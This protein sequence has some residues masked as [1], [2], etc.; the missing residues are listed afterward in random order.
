MRADS[1]ALKL[2]FYVLVRT[3]G[4]LLFLLLLSACGSS[5]VQL[6]TSALPSTTTTNPVGLLEV[7][8]A[9][10]D[11]GA[12]ITIGNTNYE[13]SY[14]TALVADN[15]NIQV[16]SSCVYKQNDTIA[17]ASDMQVYLKRP[18]LPGTSS[19][20]I[21]S[22]VAIH[23]DE[24]NSWAEL[25]PDSPE[26]VLNTYGT[27]NA[28]DEAPDVQEM[29]DG[30]SPMTAI[31]IQSPDS[32][33]VAKLQVLNVSLDAKQKYAELIDINKKTM[34]HDPKSASLRA[35]DKEELAK[36]AAKKSLITRL[37][38]PTKIHAHSKDMIGD[39]GSVVLYHAHA[40][41]ILNN[42]GEAQWLRHHKE[43]QSQPLAPPALPMA[44]TEVSNNF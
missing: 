24:D 34:N 42:R 41:A 43:A 15:G 32:S 17:D 35:E 4:S 25:E 7:K 10:P 27:L 19:Y 33:G 8:G 40:L 22:I 30:T 21:K 44:T 38:H 1:L 13:N 12:G 28:A 20:G 18:D 29:I 37:N 14:C 9:K 39:T 31:S 2:L 11:H 36:A 3:L 5:K 6:D 16:H 23:S 26:S